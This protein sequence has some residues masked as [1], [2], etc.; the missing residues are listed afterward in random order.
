MTGTFNYLSLV[1]VYV[2]EGVIVGPLDHLKG[3][4]YGFVDDGQVEK[5]VRTHTKKKFEVSLKNGAYI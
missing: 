3:I 5:P 4:F 2:E 1:V